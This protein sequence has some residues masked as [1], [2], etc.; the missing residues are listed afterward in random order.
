MKPNVIIFQQIF[1]PL[2]L[3]LDHQEK[4]DR[5]KQQRDT[6]IQKKY[7]MTAFNRLMFQCSIQIIY[8]LPYQ[9]YLSEK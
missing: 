1:D 4:Y 7:N 5:L 9:I 3:L 2:F 6:K 8:F